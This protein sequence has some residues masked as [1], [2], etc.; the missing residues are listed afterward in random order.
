MHRW[1]TILTKIP[2]DWHTHVWLPEHFGGELSLPGSGMSV[3]E[4]SPARFHATLN[5]AA[6]RYVIVG[7]QVPWVHIPNDFISEHVK[8]SRGRAI[9]LASVDP[10]SNG[11]LAELERSVE[12]LK[13]HGLKLSPYYQGFDPSCRSA[14][15]LYEYLNAAGLPLMLHMGGGGV[16]SAKLELANPVLLD[17]VARAFPDLK[18]IVAHLGQPFMQET[19]SLIR[20]HEHVYADLSARFHRP[21]Q[22]YNGLIIAKEYN[23]LSKILFGSDFPVK[24]PKESLGLFRA[25]GNITQGTNLPYITDVEIEGIIHNCPESLAHLWD[26]W[27]QTH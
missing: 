22:L 4:G 21:W 20:K 8:A 16:Q 3:E 12:R 27:N 26:R 15:E 25:L 18:I 7:L 5:D 9:G 24:T 23:I 17:P 11:A 14:W 6:E 10:N 1:E 13:L 19:V 2:V